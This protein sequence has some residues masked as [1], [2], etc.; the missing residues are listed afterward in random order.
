MGDQ[1]TSDVQ[2][3]SKTG[4]ASQETEIHICLVGGKRI[5]REAL[6]DILN[7]QQRIEVTEFC[8]RPEKLRDLLDRAVAGE[9]P[10]DVILALLTEGNFSTIHQLH[11]IISEAGLDCPLVIVSEAIGRGQVYAALRIGAKGYVDLDSSCEELCK[12]IRT[13]S[14]GKVYLAPS[15]AE[16]LVNDVSA[17]M[18]TPRSQRPMNIDLS[19]RETEIV[20]LLCEGLSSKETARRLHISVKTVENHRYNIYRK[21][22][23]DS[24]AGLMRHAI[25]HGMVTL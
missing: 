7:R 15:V 21:C 10:A 13:A 6:T 5:I 17:S 4:Q 20:Q 2:L 14:R 22:D 11:E 25:Q 19:R 9:P 1:A 18:D 16:V 8:S 3:E 23:V 24:I 12:A